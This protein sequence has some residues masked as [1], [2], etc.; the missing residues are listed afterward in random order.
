MWLPLY[1]LV[2]AGLEV[3]VEASAAVV[4]PRLQTPARGTE[5]S[6]GKGEERWG[7][8]RREQGKR[9]KKRGLEQKEG[10]KEG[11]RRR[12][13][14]ERG[15]GR[16]GEQLGEG[17]HIERSAPYPLG[18]AAVPVSPQKVVPVSPL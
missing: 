3:C 13:E 7:R 2:F 10:E 17:L 14:E 4:S 6:W 8:K 11:G 16:K 9:E 15:G 1:F 12:G 5:V 18:S